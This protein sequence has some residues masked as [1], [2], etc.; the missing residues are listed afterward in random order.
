MTVTLQPIRVSTARGEDRFLVLEDDCLVAV[1][2]RL[3]AQYGNMRA[4]GSMRPVL[5]SWMAQTIQ[6][7]PTSPTPRST[8]KAGWMSD[9]TSPPVL[10]E[11][12]PTRLAEP[13]QA[14]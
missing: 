1:L 12:L 10:A 9:V 13:T 3:S 5:A 2:V 4:A 14:R 11:H 6:Y 7:S 8:S